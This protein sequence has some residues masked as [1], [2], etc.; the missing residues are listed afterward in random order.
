M[1]NTS[2][3]GWPVVSA[4]IRKR[5][6]WMGSSAGSATATTTTTSD[7]LA[8]AGRLTRLVRGATALMAARLE[9]QSM[10]S[11][12]TRSPTQIVCPLLASRLRRVQ[13]SRWP[14]PLSAQGVSSSTQQ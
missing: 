13:S 3:T 5:V 10:P 1:E 11:N 14:C 7:T 8:T 12:R 4:V 9:G 2:S 6:S